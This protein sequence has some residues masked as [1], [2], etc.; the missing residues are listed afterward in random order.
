MPGKSSI[1]LA[2]YFSP[3]CE[4]GKSWSTRGIVLHASKSCMS[5]LHDQGKGVAMMVGML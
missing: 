2:G 4:K 1:G 3:T 5:V